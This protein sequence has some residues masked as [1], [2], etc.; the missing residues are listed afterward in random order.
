MLEELF[1]NNGVENVTI[2]PGHV[3]AY[4]ETCKNIDSACMLGEDFVEYNWEFQLFQLSKGRYIP[5]YP[6][7]T[8]GF[9]IANNPSGFVV[10]PSGLLFKCWNEI[11]CNE[12]FSVAS[13]LGK[14]TQ[15]MQRNTEKWSNWNPFDNKECVKCKYLPLCMG[16]CPYIAMRFHRLNCSRYKKYLEDIIAI[17]HALGRLH[18]IREAIKDHCPLYSPNSRGHF[19]DDC[20]LNCEQF[21]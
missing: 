11:S 5:D 7:L 4:T 1:D 18:D 20:P 2:Y 3:Q 14:A 21:S 6:V 19:S 16:G 13:V 12:D 15:E 8:Y 9:C 17:R 10:A